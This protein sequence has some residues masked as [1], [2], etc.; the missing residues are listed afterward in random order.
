MKTG[1]LRSTV[2]GVVAV[3]V[4]LLVVKIP[5]LAAVLTPDVQAVV[6]ALLI[7]LVVAAQLKVEKRFPVIGSALRSPQYGQAAKEVMVTG[8]EALENS[9]LAHHND[10]L[11]QVVLDLIAELGDEDEAD[12]EAFDE[13]EID[14]PAGEPEA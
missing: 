8:L 4:S 14:D 13:A 3:L 1:L 7:P 9:D 11:R 5:A 12:G 6:V 2:Q 10:V